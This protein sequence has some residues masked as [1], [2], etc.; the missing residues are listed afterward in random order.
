MRIIVEQAR[1]GLIQ[2]RDLVVTGTPEVVRA[3]SGP[4][5]IKFQVNSQEESAQGIDW[6]VYGQIVHVEIEKQDGSRWIIASGLTQPSEIDA[7]TGLITVNASGFSSYPDKIPWLDN[8]NPIA[9]DPFVV[10]HRIW[11]HI[12]SYA[13]GNLGV[14]VS[15][16]SSNTLLLP[17]FYYDGSKFVLDFFAYFVRAEDYRDCQ[18]EIVSLCRDIPIDFFESSAWNANRTEI[19]KTLNLAYPRGGVQR[20]ALSF[21]QGDNVQAMAPAAESE[22]DWVSDI[23]VRGW[24]PGK[25]YSSQLSNADPLRFRRV[26]K[27]EDALIN[28]RERSEVWAKRKLKRRQVPRHWGSITVDMYH[29]EAPFGSYDVGDDIYIEGYLPGVGIVEGW[30]RIL[31]MQPDDD[32]GA[33]VL[34]T[35]HVDFFNYDAIT[36]EGS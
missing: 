28:S 2:T 29:P 27:D 1:T 23:I 14:V 18:E 24:W 26:V 8:W 25:M 13:H 12:Q 10:I 16:A 3:L 20:S 19:Q 15:P 5:S 30:H 17:G 31:T 36:F 21:V 9:I 34:T 7:D 33:V 6:K 11:N 4:A 32:K 22:M 35:K